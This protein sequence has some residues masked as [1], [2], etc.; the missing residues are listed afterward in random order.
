MNKA[1][2]RS[3]VK[4]QQNNSTEVSLL[5]LLK[6]L[7]LLS[8][9]QAYYKLFILFKKKTEKLMQNFP[10]DSDASLTLKS[11]MSISL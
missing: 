10:Q 8:S 1:N 4:S 9:L 5:L 11:T 2:L 7:K 6:A 3:L